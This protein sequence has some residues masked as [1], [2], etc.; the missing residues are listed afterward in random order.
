MIC[1]RGFEAFVGGG[2]TGLLRRWVQC[3]AKTQRLLMMVARVLVQLNC[4]CMIFVAVRICYCSVLVGH[5]VQDKQDLASWYTTRVAIICTTFRSLPNSYV[6]KYTPK[7]GFNHYGSVGLLCYH[8]C[9]SR[10]SPISTNRISW[11]CMQ[12]LKTSN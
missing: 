9:V 5:V 4:K 1:C 2:F 3:A 8:G 7:S 11:A 10:C 6:V 12:T